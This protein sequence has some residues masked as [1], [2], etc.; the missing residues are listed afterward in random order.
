MSLHFP[1]TAR[2]FHIV[3]KIVNKNIY[4]LTRQMYLSS[5]NRQVKRFQPIITFQGYYS[6]NTKDYLRMKTNL[7]RLNEIKNNNNNRRNVYK[8]QK[9]FSSFDI[10][11]VFEKED[12]FVNIIL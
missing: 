2:Q 9:F 7:H 8:E 6:I 12:R 5:D 10:V 3:D 1:F 4:L 11:R